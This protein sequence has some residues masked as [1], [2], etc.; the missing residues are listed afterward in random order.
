MVFVYSRLIYLF[1]METRLRFSKQNLTEV[2]K[3]SDYLIGMAE[4][5]FPLLGDAD[6]QMSHC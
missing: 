3:L 1:H 6:F 5:S 2:P 4:N